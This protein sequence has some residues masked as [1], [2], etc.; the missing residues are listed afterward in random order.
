MSHEDRRDQRHEPGDTQEELPPPLHP[1]YAYPTQ[2][3]FCSTTFERAI[4]YRNERNA[5]LP[6][7][8]QASGS[9]KA[10]GSY[11][12]R[13]DSI[14]PDAADDP[15]KYPRPTIN[16]NPNFGW[17]KLHVLPNMPLHDFP[18][19][20]MDSTPRARAATIHP[21]V[22]HDQ[23]F[24]TSQHPRSAMPHHPLSHALDP[25][26]RS[27]GATR[28]SESLQEENPEIPYHYAP[29][30]PEHPRTVAT[31]PPPHWASYP[32]ET[33]TTMGE[34]GFSQA[35]PLPVDYPMDPRLNLH[36][37]A[38]ER[39]YDPRRDGAPYPGHWDP[40]TQPY[41]AGPYSSPY[42]SSDVSIQR[43]DLDGPHHY[44]PPP[45]WND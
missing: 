28:Y 12:K 6:V 29:P 21:S 43:H 8:Q 44:P 19:G 14:D 45:T 5:S 40:R 16:S 41:S 9:E 1:F 30:A 22:E 39:P 3:P 20:D 26:L 34:R 36:R 7:A 38:P 23:T 25:R 32:A 33:Y 10:G 37:P 15:R 42:T 2:D 17:H 11:D 27:H 13:I 4:L 18:S 35:P 31:G 24:A